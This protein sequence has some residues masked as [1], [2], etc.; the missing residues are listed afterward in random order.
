MRSAPER[1]FT[2]IELLTVIAIISILTGM[3]AVGLPRMIEKAKLTDTASDFTGIR[4]ALA[5]YM[6]DYGSYPPRYGYLSPAPGAGG[7][8]D[9]IKYF[10]VPYTAHIGLFRDFNAYDRFKNNTNDSDRDG[11]LS[12]LE[13]SPIGMKDLANPG[14]FV[15]PTSIY[16][17]LGALPADV[18]ADLDAQLKTQGPYI[19]IPVNS[20]QAKRVAKY[21]GHQFQET[22]NLDYAYARVWDPTEAMA[23]TD[24]PR[25]PLN[26]TFPPPRY[27]AFVLVSVGPKENTF[28]V[29]PVNPLGPQDDYYHILALRAYFLA[30]RDWNDDGQPDFDFNVRRKGGSAYQGTFPNPAL[31]YL[32]DGSND[33]GP[34]IF[35]QAG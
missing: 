27:D 32:P 30:T 4:G 25:N 3:V 11:V 10:L 14:K 2:L 17:P 15:F 33:Y 8:A 18:Q 20:S 22:G 31:S 9:S 29:V 26:M 16:D 1:G 5:T 7:E 34:L 21:Y 35:H 6:T 23:G 28:G 19:Y 13:F 12:Y 24:P